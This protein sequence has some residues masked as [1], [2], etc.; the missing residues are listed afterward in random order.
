[1]EQQTRENLISVCMIVRDEERYI[2]QS[3]G[4]VRRY[5]DE[6]IVLD[7]GSK[8]RTPEI[9]KLLGAKVFHANWEENFAAAR[10]ESIRHATGEW[11][12]VIDAD[13]EI[14]PESG[15]Q[16]KELVR[17]T[18][19]DAF[20]VTVRSELPE[21]DPS[22][23]DEIVL[24]R[25][26]RN[27][28]NYRYE[29][30]IHEQIRPSIERSGGVISK[31]PIIITHHGYNKEN[32]QR[33]GSRIERNVSLLKKVL[34]KEPDNPYVL[35]QLGATYKSAG[36]N[37][38]AME[39]LLRAQAEDKDRLSSLIRE[40]LYLKLGQLNLDKGNYTDAVRYAD[41][42]LEINSSNSIAMLVAA[43]SYI[44]MNQTAAAYGYLQRMEELGHTNLR[45]NTIV[46]KLISACRALGFKS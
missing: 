37:E 7:T 24:T 34:V 27:K 29:L 35:Y 39:M 30:P 25:L 6:I 42:A 23:Y 11:I 38:K 43:V 22:K 17:N 9:A 46:E 21:G 44:F 2:S 20:E 12:L 31:S 3:I 1:M 26:F 32:V 15:E 10:N 8:D 40:K 13:E 5:V 28:S 41:M 19:V 45:D 33:D 4:S 16:L 36:E 18:S 14:D